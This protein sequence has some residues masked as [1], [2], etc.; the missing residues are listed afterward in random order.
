MTVYSKTLTDDMGVADRHTWSEMIYSWDTYTGSWDSYG[1]IPVQRIFTAGITFTETL[2]Q[3][4]IFSTIAT[5]H[6]SFIDSISY[7]ENF[8]KK[9]IKMLSEALSHTEAFNRVSTAIRTLTE[10]ITH[11]DSVMHRVSKN[12]VENLTMTGSL[13]K[14]SVKRFSETLG[15]TQ[16]FSRTQMFTRTLTDA[17]SIAETNITWDMMTASWDDY[18]ENWDYY[19]KAF[20][21]IKILKRTIDD[22]ITA[23][24]TILTRILQYIKFTYLKTREVTFWGK[25]AGMGSIG[26][27]GGEK[28]FGKVS[29]DNLNGKLKSEKLF[30]KI[31][32]G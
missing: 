19:S 11:T 14:K 17:I 32:K 18:N 20:V 23:T 9:P 12:L 2:T 10:A 15:M 28:L 22:S 13:I 7:T 27:V 3:T 5:I 24:D 1:D 25:A 21:L 16:F 30:G 8:V 26:K 29:N 4:E 31:I 6:R